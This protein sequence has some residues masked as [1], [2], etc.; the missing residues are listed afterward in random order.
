MVLH[1]FMRRFGRD[2]LSVEDDFSFS[3]GQQTCERLEQGRLAGAVWSDEADDL[4]AIHFEANVPNNA[5]RSV[6]HVEV[7]NFEQSLRILRFCHLFVRRLADVSFD[8]SG[9]V[10]HGL[11][12]P[13]GELLPGI[14]H[15]HAIADGHDGF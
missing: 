3:Y 4:P 10:L 14:H 11:G 7:F 9:V 12:W 15:D 13:L 5:S 8:H 1:A 2:V 6:T